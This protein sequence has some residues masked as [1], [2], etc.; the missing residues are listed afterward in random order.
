MEKIV[1]YE[2]SAVGEV[3]FVDSEYW[4]IKAEDYVTV[5]LVAKKLQGE[6]A[7]TVVFGFEGEYLIVNGRQILPVCSP[8]STKEQYGLIKSKIEQGEELNAV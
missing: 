3:T 4:G 1:Y 7:R 2:G 5:A 8:L 6:G